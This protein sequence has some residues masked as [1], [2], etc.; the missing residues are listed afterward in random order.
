MTLLGLGTIQD[1]QFNWSHTVCKSK[2]V[3]SSYILV[4]SIVIIDFVLEYIL[5]WSDTLS[6][7]FKQAMVYM[8]SKWCSIVQLLQKRTSQS[9]RI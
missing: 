4:R 7:H 9:K 6:T 5:M 3:S 8:C 2:I 1:K